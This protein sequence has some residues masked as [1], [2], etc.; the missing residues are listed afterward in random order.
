MTKTP[1]EDRLMLVCDHVRSLGYHPVYVCLHGSQNY[2]MDIFTDEYQSD[3][4]YKCVV[5]PNLESLCHNAAPVSTTL[6]YEG[7]HIDLKDIRCFME[8][9]LKCNPSYMETLYTPHAIMI[10]EG[11]SLFKELRSSR[12]KLLESMAPVFIKALYGM[13]ME[14]KKAMCHPYP[15][16]FHKIEKYGYDGK[17]VHHMYRLLLML[18]DFQETGTILLKPPAESKE[19]L[20]ELKLNK[21][22][23]EVAEILVKEFEQELVVLRQKLETQYPNIDPSVKQQ[24]LKFSQDAV[25]EY[26]LTPEGRKKSE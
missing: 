20:L 23:L 22:P 11:Q 19:L 18:Y 10:D 15:T 2:E 3:F 17:Q 25:F 4:D 7:G 9:L 21:Y 1:F 5:L 6:D 13:F 24:L 12:D 16:I 26:C 8:T 14:K